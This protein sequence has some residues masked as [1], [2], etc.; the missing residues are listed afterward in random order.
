MRITNLK[1]KSEA[2]VVVFSPAKSVMA[3]ASPEQQ[4][5]WMFVDFLITK[6]YLRV[7]TLQRRKTDRRDE[8]L[9]NIGNFVVEGSPKT[10]LIADKRPKMPV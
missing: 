8:K 2:L 10:H 9:L 7:D 4:Q 6:K 5:Q 3:V 1:S